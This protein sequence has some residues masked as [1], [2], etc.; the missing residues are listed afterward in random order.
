MILVCHLR[1]SGELRQQRL[2]Y[3]R[4]RALQLGNTVNE[5]K[6]I[7]KTARSEQLQSKSI[8]G[9]RYDGLITH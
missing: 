1:V 4:L 9:F 3:G 7:S 6:R 8:L 5:T 2:C